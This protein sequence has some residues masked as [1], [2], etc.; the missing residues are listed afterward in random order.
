LLDGA[1][2]MA[3]GDG[4]PG[5]WELF[6]FAEAELVAPGPTTCAMRL[7]GQAGTDAL[8]PDVWPVGSYVVRIGPAVGQIDLP[9][10]ARGMARH[11]RIGPAARG[12]EDP[13]Y[14][15]R[16]ES[17]EGAGLRPLVAMSSEGA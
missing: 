8:M 5:N 17:F 2:L 9:S 10:Q 7:R 3:I 4:T 15:Y 11:F 12:Y 1:N 16:V 6:Q 13:S 14:I